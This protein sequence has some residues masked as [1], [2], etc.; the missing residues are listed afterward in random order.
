[1]D[2]DFARSFLDETKRIIDALDTRSIEGV[3][4]GIGRVRERGGASSF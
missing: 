4:Q 3:A 1:M 2:Q